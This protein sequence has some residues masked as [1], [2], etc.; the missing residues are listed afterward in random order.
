MLVTR[1]VLSV[2]RGG[3][4]GQKRTHLCQPPVLLWLFCNTERSTIPVTTV[5]NKPKPTT[6]C[7]KDLALGSLYSMSGVIAVYR[8]VVDAG[9]CTGTGW[10]EEAD[11]A[12]FEPG[13][14]ADPLPSDNGCAD[15]DASAV[16]S[17]PG[18]GPTAAD[19]GCADVGVRTSCPSVADEGAHS[20]DDCEPCK[21]EDLSKG[22]ESCGGD[23]SCNDCVNC[24]GVVPVVTPG[25]GR[26]PRRLSDTV[27]TSSGAAAKLLPAS[28]TSCGIAGAAITWL[29]MERTRRV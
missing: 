23:P 18:P 11:A 22:N 21:D 17:G 8:E 16:E 24:E 5:A 10:C 29:R 12:V 7:D 20:F 13:T 9:P 1:D 3:G 25:G 6:F 15:V 28:R 4:R 26:E 14:G 19:K 2:L 27:A